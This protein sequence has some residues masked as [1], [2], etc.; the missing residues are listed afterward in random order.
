MI[1]LPSLPGILKAENERI[2]TKMRGELVSSELLSLVRKH[3]LRGK[4]IHHANIAALMHGENIHLLIGYNP[5]DFFP[6][7]DIQ[8]LSPESFLQG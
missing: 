7:S 5:E 2:I 1:L 4:R 8:V 3:D 6:F